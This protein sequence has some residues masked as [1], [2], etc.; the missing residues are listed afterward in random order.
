MNGDWVSANPLI[1]MELQ[2]E[3]PFLLKS[4]TL[5][6]TIL[7]KSPCDTDDCP[8]YQVYFNRSDIQWN[9]AT[10]TSPFQ[11]RFTPVDLTPGSYT[12]QVNSQDPSGNPSGTDPYEIS[13]VVSSEEV[14]SL[15]SVLPNPSSALFFF[16]AVVLG[17][18]TSDGKLEI[19]QSDGR[20]VFQ[21]SL[22]DRLHV[23]TNR[24]S[25]AGV[26]NEGNDLSNGMYIYRLMVVQAG[27]TYTFSGRLVLAR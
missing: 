2:D 21:S 18:E 27:K 5:A 1:E 25:W 16:E 8:F 9:P 22:R 23:G 3:N 14:V 19:F 12:L 24:F 4:D 17:T 11:V 26:S 10:A 15:Q 20:P 13:F 7:L 6:F